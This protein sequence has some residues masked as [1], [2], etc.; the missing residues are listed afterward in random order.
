M[1]NEANPKQKIS[2]KSW[3][4][5]LWLILFFPVGLY[6]MWKSSW[7][8]II[9]IIITII[10]I[11]ALIGAIA[12]P[13][14][15]VSTPPATSPVSAAETSAADISAKETAAD[16]NPLLNYA[17]Q[18]ADV[19]NGSGTE[20]IGKW[21]S[22]TVSKKELKEYTQED[23]MDFI[24]SQVDGSG[25]NWFTIIFEDGTGLQ[26]NGSIKQIGT[27]GTIDSEGCI[28]ERIGNIVLKSDD[29][30]EYSAAESDI[31]EPAPSESESDSGAESDTKAESVPTEYLSALVTAETYSSIMHMSK[32]GIYNQLTSEYGENFS[33]EAAQYAVDHMTADWNE[34]ALKKAEEYSD[35]M[36]MSKIGVYNQL[37]SEY[38]ELFTKEEAQYAVD[39]LN[40]DWKGNALEKAKEYQSIMNM[41]PEA[42]RQ[43]LTS[44]YGESFT[45]EEAD[46]AIANLN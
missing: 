26:F 37:V 46:Y 7:N 30:Y 9:K 33:A 40:A 17:I 15:S 42:I 5:I 13:S 36:H 38:G 27:Y 24:N 44:E 25:Y 20:V 43:Q 21:A 14:S 34:N 22:I 11:L 23:F 10:F 8:K 31:S 1:K 32:A 39:H 29:T 6:F 4:I 35:T 41:S 3:F 2:E 12:S 28:T 18:E 19:K 45:Q 16:S